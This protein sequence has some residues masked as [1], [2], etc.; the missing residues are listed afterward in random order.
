MNNPGFQLLSLS[1]SRGHAVSAP[2]FSTSPC[3]LPNQLHIF[4]TYGIAF[5]L[6]LIVVI[7]DNWIR[8]AGR[9]SLL[10]TTRT[11]ES[12]DSSTGK[13]KKNSSRKHVQVRNLVS[14]CLLDLR[15]LGVWGV[16]WYLWLIW[17]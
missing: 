9:D 4:I 2:G 17:Y 1:N 15:R 8:L 3:I 11:R 7:I 5:I 12:D 10:P 13:W 14:G 16:V 6:T